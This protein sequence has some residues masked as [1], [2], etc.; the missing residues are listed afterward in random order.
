MSPAPTVA[1]APKQAAGQGAH[2]AAEQEQP[3][4]P[5]H[6]FGVIVD[7]AAP[8]GGMVGTASPAVRQPT[9]TPSPA[10]A[11]YMAG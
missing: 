10:P 3:R 9:H 7:H 8:S 4:H 5:Q 6:Q 11:R 1:P 2:W